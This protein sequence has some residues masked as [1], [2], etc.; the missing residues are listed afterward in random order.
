MGNCVGVANHKFFI[1]FTGY[2]GATLLLCFLE[3]FVAYYLTDFPEVNTF[4][5]TVMNVN[6]WTMLVLGG[7]IFFLFTYQFKNAMR[8][9]TTVEDNFPQLANPDLNPFG[10]NKDWFSN[11][12]S[13]FGRYSWVDWLLPLPPKGM[14]S[15]AGVL[16]EVKTMHNFGTTGSDEMDDFCGK[17]KA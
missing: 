10:R 6:M 3:E 16:N 5:D 15:R 12:E 14:P 11:L 2:A 4:E 1:Q 17:D 9:V 7:A 13:I 8:N